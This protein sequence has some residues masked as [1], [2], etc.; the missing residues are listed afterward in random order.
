MK[1]V[2]TVRAVAFA[3]APDDKMYYLDKLFLN[4]NNWKLFHSKLNIRI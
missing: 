3:A 4:V 1:H 2:R